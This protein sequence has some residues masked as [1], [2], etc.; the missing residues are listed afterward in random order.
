MSETLF[1]QQ[2]VALEKSFFLFPGDAHMLPMKSFQKVLHTACPGLWGTVCQNTGHN[3][4]L[5]AANIPLFLWI[6]FH[7]ILRW[8]GNLMVIESASFLLVGFVDYLI[9]SLK[10]LTNVYSFIWNVLW[11]AEKRTWAASASLCSLEQMVSG[12]TSH[13]LGWLLV[14]SSRLVSELSGKQFSWG[15]ITE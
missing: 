12:A 1:L 5:E 6:P 2:Y 11:G 15:S 3:P 8:L 10:L 4:C 7:D 13:G 9:Q 14:F